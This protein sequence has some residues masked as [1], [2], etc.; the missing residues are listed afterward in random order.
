MKRNYFQSKL[1]LKYIGSYLFILLVPLILLT[2]VIYEST[3]SNLRT[4]IEQNSLD[5][6][7]QTKLIIDSRMKELNDI[8]SRI[9]YDTR[10]TSYRVHHPW[11][12]GEAIQ[13][14]DQ[15]KATSTMITEIF[16]YFH[17]DEKILSSIGLYDF[18]VFADNFRYQNWPKDAAYHDLNH[19]KA[20]TMY[21]ADLVYRK[22][23][24]DKYLTYLVP[25]TPNSPNPYGTVMYLIKE[26]GIKDLI[27]SI[28]GDFQG[29]TLILDHNGKI[30]A[31]NDPGDFLKQTDVSFLLELPPGIQNQV[32][33]HQS[34]SIISVQSEINGWTY[35][36]LIPS[37]QFFSS[38]LHVRSLILILFIIVVT[39]GAAASLMFARFMYQPI[40]TLVEFADQTAK[41]NHDHPLMPPTGD[42][43]DRIRIAL[44]E[45][46]SRIDL[47]EP[48]A[49]NHFLTLLLRY[50]N[51]DVLTPEL[52]EV[53]D[54]HFEDYSSHFVM[55]LGWNETEHSQENLSERRLIINM[56]SKIELPELSAKG[57]GVELPQLDRGALIMSFEP[58]P[59]KDRFVQ[60]RTIVEA[61][62]DNLHEAA[63]ITPIIGVG[64]CYP[65]IE[66]LNQ[67]YIEACSAFEMRPGSGEQ[68]AIIY[69]EQLSHTHKHPCWVPDNVLLKLSQSLKQGNY[70][71]AAQMIHVAVESLQTLDLPALIKRCIAFDIQNT[72]LKTAS[73]L[74]IHHT[75]QDIVPNMINNNSITELEQGFLSLASQICSQVVQNQQ[76]QDESLTDQIVA[77]INNHYADHM[78]SLDAVALEFSVSP[79]Y[80]SRS[81][82]EKLGVNFT[83][84]IWQKRL[85]EVKHQLITTN[86][87]VKDII[88]R[89]G[90]LDAPNFIR[91]FK[92]ETGCTPGQYRKLNAGVHPNADSQPKA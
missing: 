73:E 69:F 59:S 72:I 92:K 56:L 77:Y 25:I 6:L 39:A 36:S 87:P 15:Y 68:G 7:T 61:V 10:L 63:D 65:S 48:Y 66:Q 28:L 46:S 84:Y 22:N 79:S 2:I 62:R 8:A 9:S 82:K 47:Q 26:T 13:A 81:F 86:D 64:T 67:S 43:L 1:F 4:Q 54:L 17:D 91:K 45:Y 76:Q 5:Q 60:I 34:H 30:L 80:V 90:Y 83:Q 71:V 24:Q 21:P 3:V 52:Q 16:L 14:L 51:T 85:E 42:E 75:M 31:S 49:R 58:D 23:K 18:D 55:V 32:I 37:D 88:A 20:P 38:V 53:F 70:E 41:E 57:Y 19:L 33:N 12:S 29:I 11:Y 40:S 78:L 50:G 44:Q 35:I 27:D 89:V 74:K